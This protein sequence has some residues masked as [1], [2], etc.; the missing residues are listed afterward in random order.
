MTDGEKWERE[1]L[2]EALDSYTR[3]LS[4]APH[5]RKWADKASAIPDS[6]S[7]SFV[8]STDD[9]DRH[10]DIISVEGW[11]LQ[12]YSRNPVFLWAHNYT[13]PAI[14]R[15]LAVWKEEHSLIAK[16]E[17]APTD[18]AREV[19][20]LYHGGYQRGVS[21]GFK[22]LQYEVRSDRNTGE[23]LGINFIK[24]ELLEISAAPVPANQ[25]ALRKALHTTPRLQAYYGANFGPDGTL[26]EIL[27][28]LRSAV[29]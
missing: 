20:A 14:G 22:P 7:M 6:A 2:L 4:D 1:R 21:V 27:D 3:G 11:Q 29:V 17:F 13:Q 10:G 18:F 24:Q 5:L 26:E 28:V 8:I 16:M 9:V 23:V 15:A 12:S 19:A 25:N